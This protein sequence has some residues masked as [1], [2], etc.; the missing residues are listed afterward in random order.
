[1]QKIYKFLRGKFLYIEISLIGLIIITATLWI[2]NENGHYEPFTVLF[3]V[4]LASLEFLKIK[5]AE[6]E[7]EKSP[8][9]DVDVIRAL[10]LNI[11]SYTWISV[12]LRITNNT[13]HSI[14]LADFRLD[15]V[16]V[17]AKEKETDWILP[18]EDISKIPNSL[19]NLSEHRQYINLSSSETINNTF[20]IKLP[21][22]HFKHSPLHKVVVIAMLNGTDTKI[23]HSFNLSPGSFYGIDNT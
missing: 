6:T 16:S 8:I 1:M 20:T 13:D 3:S 2:F 7:H 5:G 19:T 11:K 14:N 22:N 9:L 23:A 18:V 17:A 10:H 12:Y 4:F 15:C 21:T